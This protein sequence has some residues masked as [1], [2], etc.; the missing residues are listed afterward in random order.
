MSA[1]ASLPQDEWGSYLMLVVK[2]QP[3]LPKEKHI[4]ST[5]NLIAIFTTMQRRKPK[6]DEL[7]E[8][9]MLRFII[10]V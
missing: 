2:L 4:I 9:S 10:L 5:I 7:A 3:A 8:P 6:T 1:R